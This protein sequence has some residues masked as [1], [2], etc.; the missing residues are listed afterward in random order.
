AQLPGQR[1][2]DPGA[3]RADPDGHQHPLIDPAPAAAARRR[4]S[5]RRRG[6]DVAA[7]GG[8]G[9]PRPPDRHSEVRMDKSLYI[10]MTG[11]SAT[12]RGTVAAPVEGPGL[13]S[14]V[15]ASQRTLGVSDAA[16]ARTTTG[17]PLDVALAPGHWL[18]VQDRNGGVAYTRAGDLQLNQNGLLNTA[19]GLQVLDEGGAPMALP[20]SD[21][22]E[23]GGDGTVSVVPQGQ[24][25][26]TMAAVGRL[27][28]VAIDT[29]A[30]V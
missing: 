4:R 23:I 7:A 3:G 27:Q 12:L 20:P 21:A 14:R 2:D 16:G 9:A 29:R 8:M 15:A 30:M 19:S 17:N 5:A 22:I 1:A 11:A 13:A 28:V 26:A 25:M 18:A 10:A 24:P 6:T